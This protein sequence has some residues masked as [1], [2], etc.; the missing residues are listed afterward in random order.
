MCTKLKHYARAAHKIYGP[1][2]RAIARFYTK[3]KQTMVLFTCKCYIATCYRWIFSNIL[4]M[5]LNTMAALSLIILS[6]RDHFS[7]LGPYYYRI[8]VRTKLFPRAYHN[9]APRQ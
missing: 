7:F 2:H 3:T 6:S 9:T 4:R 8:D 1:L 5:H